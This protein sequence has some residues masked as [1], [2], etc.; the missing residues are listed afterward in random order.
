M[1]TAAGGQ[2]LNPKPNGY[3]SCDFQG[4]PSPRY[5]SFVDRPAY[6][7]PWPQAGAGWLPNFFMPLDA[8]LLRLPQLTVSMPNTLAPSVTAHQAHP[9]IRKQIF[10]AMPPGA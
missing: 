7:F 2:L 8:G 4:V 6:A 10:P 9:T 1:I 3:T 5:G